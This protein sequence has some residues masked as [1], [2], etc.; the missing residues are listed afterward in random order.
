MQRRAKFH[1]AIFM[2][3]A[4]MVGTDFTGALLLVTPIEKEY[5]TNITTTQWVLNIYA[6]TFAMF[7]VAG[8]RFGDMYGRRRLMLI[9]L[10][11][12]LLGSLGCFL[13]PSIGL[14][15]AARGLQ[16]IG[17][18]IIWPSLLALGANA[19]DKDERGLAI[20]LV[21]AGVTTGNVAG[22]LI[23]GVV[24]SIGDW[25]L[26]F[27][28]N[29]AMAVLAAL[30]MWRIQPND[31]RGHGED[32]IDY[33]GMAVLSAAILTLLYGLDV[34]ADWGWTSLGLVGL[35]TTS[36]ILFLSFPFVEM[37]ATNPMIPLSMMWDRQFI[38]A[39]LTNGLIIPAVFIAFLY[40]P[41]YLQITLGW[42]VLQSSFG[43]MPLMMLGVFGAVFAGR[44]YNT[45]GPRRLLVVG[46]SVTALGCLWVALLLDPSWGYLA[47]VPAM[48]LVGGGASI[49]VGP[50]GTLAVSAA[51]PER[52]ALAGGLSFMVH[53]V[54]GAL[55][56]A[57]AT[58]IMYATQSAGGGDA[59]A[60]AA[61]F[62]SGMSR[63]YWLPLIA[64]VLGILVAAAINEKK[65]RAV[66][67]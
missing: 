29:V 18:A 19:A 39:L 13:A 41:Q 64:A 48:L 1:I 67:T 61:L 37:R 7:M 60:Q 8:G 14:L 17:A 11:I 36:L 43:I 4:F 30:L 55:G 59:N 66:D 20:G 44:F 9:G 15:I 27:L 31:P 49:C 40:F 38:L 32:R 54:L 2:F 6:L 33:F 63:A 42:S 45:F 12:F 58:A 57:G 25:R 56:V 21:L 50:A 10:A 52:S 62:A 46:S 23:S 34:G 65:L 47:L 22:P 3:V 24:I 5:A 35:L 53:L 51:G 28:A 26:F 16:G